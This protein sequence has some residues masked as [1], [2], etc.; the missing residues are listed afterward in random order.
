MADGPGYRCAVCLKCYKR[1]EHLR[2]HEG[3]HSIERRHQ[4]DRCASAFQ[5][6]DALT[7]HLKTCNGKSHAVASRRRAC[8]QCARQKKAC[9]SQQPC[10]HCRKKNVPCRYPSHT[11]VDQSTASVEGELGTADERVPSTDFTGVDSSFFG[12]WSLENLPAWDCAV[13]TDPAFDFSDMDWRDF[14]V[15]EEGDLSQEQPA[16]NPGG[17]RCFQFLDR[18]TSKT[19]LISSFECGTHQQRQSI[20]VRFMASQ[21]LAEDKAQSSWPSFHGEQLPLDG[22]MNMDNSA[23]ANTSKVGC[24][25][26]DP[27]QWQTQQITLLVQEV[28]TMKPRNSTVTLT[29]SHTLEQICLQFFSPFNLRKYLE[30]YWTIWHPNVNFVHRLTFDPVTC[31]SV[32]LASM[33]I[34]GRSLMH[35]MPPMILILTRGLCFT[36]FFGPRKFQNMV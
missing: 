20:L 18:F 19:G 22:A 31:K 2:R 5:R 26:P 11:A 6:A 1:P 35:N 9:D 34:I 29:W 21:R 25:L 14:F 15:F 23:A 8:D 27:L 24:F 33:A 7:R 3:S 17:R 30:M 32:L 13:G 36:R 12:D 4:C 10:N 16:S 28:I